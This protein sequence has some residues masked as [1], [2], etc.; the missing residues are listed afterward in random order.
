MVASPTTDLDRIVEFGRER[1]WM[2]RIPLALLGC[3]AGLFMLAMDPVPPGPVPIAALCFLLLVGAAVGISRFAVDHVMD[4][5][6]PVWTVGLVLAL[7]LSVV[8]FFVVPPRYQRSSL[9]DVSLGTLGWMFVLFSLGYV[10]FALSKHVSPERPMLSLS[11]EGVRLHI[12]WLKGLLIPW[13]EI[14][15]VGQLEHVLPGGTIS[16]HPGAVV[17]AMSH[18]FYERHILPR[19]TFLSGQL[20]SN[21]FQ[22]RN[23]Q[24]GAQVG[25]QIQMLLPYTW[26]SISQEDM[27]QP[28][29]ARWKAFR[30]RPADAPFQASNEPPLRMSTWSPGT[31]TR[32]QQLSLAAPMACA[33]LM[34]AHFGGLWD[35]AFLRT[36]RED[37]GKERAWQDKVK[38]AKQ[39]GEYI[40]RSGQR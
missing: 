12:S 26:F 27:Q 10:A 18:D 25:E 30:E 34:L 24:S 35:T 6:K 32:W 28:V 5:P 2:N 1:Y 9:L 7:A 8:V 13:H 15:R 4:G 16:R 33:L 40:I 21:M 38:D 31:L 17:V 11:P 36:A 37:F 19:R 23:P 3:A 20:W 29:E 22:P 14:E 39:K